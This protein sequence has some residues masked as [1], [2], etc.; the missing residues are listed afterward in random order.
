MTM[1]KV[2]KIL[3]ISLVVPFFIDNKDHTV[4]PK[5]PHI[6]SH[7]TIKY[8]QILGNFNHISMS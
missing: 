3:C 5:Q 8:N 1:A 4:K 6:S 2:F 7:L